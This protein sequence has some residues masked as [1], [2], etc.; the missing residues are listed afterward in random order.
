MQS[1]T[2]DPLETALNRL[3]EAITEGWR[4]V[5]INLQHQMKEAD[6]KDFEYTC[7]MNPE[8]KELEKTIL[9]KPKNNERIR[10]V[11]QP[12]IPFNHLKRLA[13]NG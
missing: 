1:F 10:F 7:E 13:A 5:P 8:T 4:Q 11:E 3:K 9:E 12:L 2:S 6:E